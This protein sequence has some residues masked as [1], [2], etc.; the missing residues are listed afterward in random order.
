MFVAVVDATAAIGTR[1][2]GS[3]TFA[4]VLVNRQY[5]RGVEQVDVRTGERHEKLPGASMGG[6]NWTDRAR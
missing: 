1:P 4:T 6:T 2:I 3:G 5:L